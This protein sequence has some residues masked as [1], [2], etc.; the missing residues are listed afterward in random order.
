MLPPSGGGSNRGSG[1]HA[2]CRGHRGRAAQ[3]VYLAHRA[4]RRRETRA[5]RRYH[6]SLRRCQRQRLR[7]EDRAPD[8]QDPKNGQEEYDEQETL[9]D[10]YKRALSMVAPLE[11]KGLSPGG[12][13]STSPSR[14]STT[15]GRGQTATGGGCRACRTRAQLPRRQEHDFPNNGLRQCQ[16]STALRL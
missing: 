9:L 5:R 12:G 1:D 16:C 7:T 10:L 6:G 4:A 15:S 8:H 11:R 3:I 2:G 13:R 14:D